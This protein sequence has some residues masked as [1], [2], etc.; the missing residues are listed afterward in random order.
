[1]KIT[2]HIL[3]SIAVMI[4]GLS[5]APSALRA[6]PPLTGAI[7]TT[8]STCTDVNVNIYDHKSDVYIDGGPSHPGAAGLPDGNYCVQVTDPSGQTVLG[9]SAPGA[10]TVVDGEFVAC[11][12]LTTILNT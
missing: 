10:V 9:L 1:M 5:L 2:S 12:Q 6:A 7:F 11:Y 4:A 3:T 8:D